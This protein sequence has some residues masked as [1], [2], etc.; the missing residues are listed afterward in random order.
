M[1]FVCVLQEEAN[2][3]LE[4]QKVE[5]D[6]L[7]TT[8]GGRIPGGGGGGEGEGGGGGGGGESTTGKLFVPRDVLMARAN[9]LKKAVR[10]VLDMTEREIESQAEVTAE[11]NSLLQ[12]VLNEE[13]EIHASPNLSPCS[14]QSSIDSGRRG[15]DM[16]PQSLDF[17]ES[18][19]SVDSGQ[20]SIDS[21]TG[22]FDISQPR[23]SI[24]SE[25]RGMD[26][27]LMSSQGGT[28]SGPHTRHN[29]T[30]VSSLVSVVEPAP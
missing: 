30:S 15:S 4:Q 22:S 29:R 7:T 9:S 2:A 27:G 26:L 6:P 21:R 20:R 23:A 10:S 11:V 13:S 25:G 17:F 3:A 19:G 18:R 16:G 28:E 8:G 24:D 12:P 5:G 14:S 1:I